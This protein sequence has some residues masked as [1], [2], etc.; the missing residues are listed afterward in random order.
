M[1]MPR[2]QPA[3]N[4][5]ITDGSQIVEQIGVDGFRWVE[6]RF[7]RASVV[8]SVADLSVEPLRPAC[9]RCQIKL[10]H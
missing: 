3:V 2:V 9:Q 4:E 7:T 8:V 6:F 10:F 1:G 5:F